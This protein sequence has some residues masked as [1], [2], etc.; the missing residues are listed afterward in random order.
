MRQSV[1]A[2]RANGRKPHRPRTPLA[3]RSARWLAAR[4]GAAGRERVVERF[5]WR[6]VAEQTVAWYRQTFQEQ[7][8]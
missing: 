4:L 8:C 6:A 5:T 2:V 1:G 7:P 3:R